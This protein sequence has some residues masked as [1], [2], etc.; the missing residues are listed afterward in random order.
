[1]TVTFSCSDTKVGTIWLLRKTVD[2]NEL[3]DS[4]DSTIYELDTHSPG[5][6]GSLPLTPEMLPQFAE[7]RYLRLEP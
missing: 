3:L 6:E 2:Y 7:R 5:P 4:N 1:M